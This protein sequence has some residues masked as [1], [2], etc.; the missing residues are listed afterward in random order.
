MALPSVIFE[1]G[2]EG[3]GQ[4]ALSQDHVSGL[5]LYGTAPGSFA[6]TPQQAVFSVADAESKGITNDY[7]YETKALAIFN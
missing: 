2:K 6:T 7:S 3:L 5:V 4:A 1:L